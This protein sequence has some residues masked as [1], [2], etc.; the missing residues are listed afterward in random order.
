MC[1]GP[2]YHQEYKHYYQYLNHLGAVVE[3]EKEEGEVE[4][5]SSQ[6]VLQVPLQPLFDNL[7]NNTYEVFERDQVKYVRYGEAVRLALS[8]LWEGHL[9]GSDETIRLLV[10]GG[11]RV[12]LVV[13]ALEA[14]ASLGLHDRVS[15][16]VLEKVL[17]CCCS[18]VSLVFSRVCRILTRSVFFSTKASTLPSSPWFRRMRGST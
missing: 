1:R 2:N 13:K 17:L 15:I 11:G 9:R 4:Y 6:D 8:E 10:V 3:E 18:G 14:A 5:A 16:T 7:S 12:P